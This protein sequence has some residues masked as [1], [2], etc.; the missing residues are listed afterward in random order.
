VTRKPKGKK[1]KLRS[2]TLCTV[3]QGRSFIQGIVVGVESRLKGERPLDCEVW[4]EV[5]DGFERSEKGF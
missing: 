5:F 4:D 1:I 3:R 2:D